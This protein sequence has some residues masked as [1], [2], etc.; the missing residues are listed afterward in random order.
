[1]II[2]K[3]GGTLEA[4]FNIIQRNR[5]SGRTESVI[6]RIF[7]LDDDELWQRI[8]ERFPRYRQNYR[9]IN[10]RQPWRRK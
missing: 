5:D 4:I 3:V 9:P 1:M 7:G 8:R 6:E 2:R 10:N